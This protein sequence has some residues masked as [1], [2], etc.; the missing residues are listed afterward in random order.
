VNVS[1]GVIVFICA[2]VIVIV[3]FDV[4]G[5]SFVILHGSVM[6]RG[7]IVPTSKSQ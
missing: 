4:E 7:L 6:I 2:I 1:E 3:R 5:A